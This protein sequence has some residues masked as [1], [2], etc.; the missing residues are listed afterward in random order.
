MRLLR[1]VAPTEGIGVVES[2]LAS[3]NLSNIRWIV[4]CC[5]S[6]RGSKS[7]ARLC[8]FLS[9]SGMKCIRALLGSRVLT[10]VPRL[11]YF[12]SFC[13]QSELGEQ[14]LVIHGRGLFRGKRRRLF[15]AR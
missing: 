12:L 2:C 1:E 9:S 10:S 13:R 11:L 5:F 15:I 6:E 14:N 4:F 7:D 8:T 3:R